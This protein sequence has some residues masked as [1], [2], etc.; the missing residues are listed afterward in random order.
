MRR[1]LGIPCL[2]VAIAIMLVLPLDSA[3]A[4]PGCTC[5]PTEQTPTL[6]GQGGSCEEAEADLSS[7]L[8]GYVDCS[9][10]WCTRNLVITTTCYCDET[11]HHVAGYIA[12]RCWACF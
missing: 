3:A 4:P 1:L 7:Q 10:G 6:W 2:L 12:Y 8:N 5:G 11:G 9:D